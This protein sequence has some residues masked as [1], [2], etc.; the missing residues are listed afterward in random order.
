MGKRLAGAA[1]T[2]GL[3]YALVQPAIGAVTPLYSIDLRV[4]QA[5]RSLLEKNLDLYRWRG[6][7]RMDESQLR[8]LVG[9]APAQIRDFL[10][11]EGF[12]SPRIGINLEVDGAAWSVAL[13]VEPGEPAKVGRIDLRIIGPLEHDTVNSR[14]R[15]E[16]LRAGW[17]LRQ[18]AV[19]RHADWESAKRAALRA[20]LV[21][22]YPAA[23]IRASQATVNP[24][25]GL[26][27]LS[28]T[29]DS[30][31]A[32]SFGA[33]RIQGLTRYPAEIVERLNPLR[34]G[35][36]YVQERLLELQ[37]RLQ[38]SPYFSSVDV[39]LDI[40]PEHPEAVPIDIRVEENHARSLGLGIGASTDTGPRAQVNYRDLNLLGQA[41]RLTGNLKLARKEQTLGGELQ[42][43]PTRDNVQN[44]LTSEWTRTNIE[45]EVTRTLTLGAKRAH[46]QGKIEIDYALRYYSEQQD[47][48]GAASDNRASL[49]PSWSWTRRDVDNPLYPRRGYLLNLQADAAHRALLSDRSFLRGYGKATWF[50]PVGAH[51]QVI[52]RGELGAVAAKSRDGIPSDFLFRTGGD[53]TVRGYAYQ[54]LGVR[55]GNAI[56]GGRWLAVASAEYVHWLTPA[57]GAALFVDAGDAADQAGDLDPVVGYG[58]GARWKSPVG[59]LGLDLA[60]GRDS[61][62]TRLHFAVG[63]SF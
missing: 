30:G 28:L 32:F 57:W 24:E 45:G 8:R 26:V 63:F 21:D 14:A 15:L 10:A 58:L 48:A 31:P 39:H 56:V 2:I 4:P 34:P 1:L 40:D 62:E 43:P 12:Y 23:E 9:Q 7:E 5:Q 18:G 44:S 46:L 61:G 59:L 60:H 17:T 55:E 19:F 53:Q 37:T 50:Y 20:L 54:S 33:T 49:V 13:T 27:D 16:K 29:L 35:E 25:A 42:F 36:P 47:I 41:W 51:G 11:S 22:R 6:S 38:D 3:L 52:L